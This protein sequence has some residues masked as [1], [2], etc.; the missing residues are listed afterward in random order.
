MPDRFDLM[1]PG[2]VLAALRVS[3]RW[4]LVV[5]RS[6]LQG[7][8]LARLQAA[9]G[10]LTAMMSE[11]SAAMTE[12]RGVERAVF[13]VAPDLPQVVGERDA[14]VESFRR[15]IEVIQATLSDIRPTAW[16][17]DLAFGAGVR[18]SV[19]DL[20]RHMARVAQIAGVDRQWIWQAVSCG[21]ILPRIG[22]TVSL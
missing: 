17:T 14:V 16:A 5:N 10:W 21:T 20:G 4:C 9:T 11:F 1:E 7:E 8:D 12:A 3:S 6:D 15:V 18:V 22:A 19:R 13:D 2:E